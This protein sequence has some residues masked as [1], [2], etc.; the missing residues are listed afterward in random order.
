M[1]YEFKHLDVSVLEV[2]MELKKDDMVYVTMHPIN[3]PQLDSSEPLSYGIMSL[4]KLR[5][6]D[7]AIEQGLIKLENCRINICPLERLSTK[8]FKNTLEDV[9]DDIYLDNEVDLSADE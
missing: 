8:C 4:A 7:T 5:L 3:T 2:R 6:L 9:Q 1:K